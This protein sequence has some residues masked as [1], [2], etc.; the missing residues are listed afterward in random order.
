MAFNYVSETL[1]TYCDSILSDVSIDS[2][3]TQK[4]MDISTYWNPI[5]STLEFK[6]YTDPINYDINEGEIFTAVGELAGFDNTPEIRSKINMRKTVTLRYPDPE[7][8][9]NVEIYYD[10]SFNED[11]FNSNVKKIV[12]RMYNLITLFRNKKTIIEDYG[13]ELDI[14]SYTFKF[15]LYNN[16]RR[17]NPRRSGQEYLESLNNSTYKCFN[18][19]SGETDPFGPHVIISR[20]EESIGLL[21]HEILHAVFFTSSLG[22]LG[23]VNDNLIVNASENLNLGEMLVN[24]V[25]SIIHAYLI[26]Y[27]TNLDLD[28]CLKYEVIHSLNQTS[29]LGKISGVRLQ[30][31]LPPSRPTNFFQNAYMFEYIYGRALILSNYAYLMENYATLRDELHNML[32]GSINQDLFKDEIIDLF[33]KDNSEMIAILNILDTRLDSLIETNQSIAGVDSD[34]C[35]NM[36]MQYFCLDPIQVDEDKRLLNL[37]GGASYKQKYLKYKSKYLQ[38]KNKIKKY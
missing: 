30:N 10:S 19:S 17:A 27:E 21:T 11:N 7:N 26:H 8:S 14:F 3:I 16:P 15:Y 37:Y 25:G 13:M 34:D 29:R 20:L 38:L 4:V 2:F 31:I 18:T 1:K 35:G 32:I 33:S 23:R 12:T 36:I 22:L 5:F 24:S 6:N 28:Q 9:I